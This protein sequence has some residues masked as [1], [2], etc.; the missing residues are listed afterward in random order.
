MGQFI[1]GLLY[2]NVHFITI[3]VRRK[4]FEYNRVF[5]SYISLIWTVIKN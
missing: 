4:L 5:V 1:E 2:F 3:D